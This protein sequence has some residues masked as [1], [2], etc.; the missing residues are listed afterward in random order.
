MYPV[1]KT[2]LRILLIV[3]GIVCFNA[4]ADLLIDISQGYDNPKKIAVVPFGGTEKLENFPQMAGII[5][6]D[7]ARSG[8]FTP[9][10]TE[11]ML[12]LPDRPSGVFFRDWRV[13]GVDFLLIG[14]VQKDYAGEISVSYHLYDVFNEREL[15]HDRLRGSAQ[16]GRDVAHR[17]SDKVYEKIT[18]IPGAFSTKIMYVLVQNLGSKAVLFELKLADSDGERARTLL[19]SREPILSDSW[20]PDGKSIT[21]VSFEGGKPSI[22]LQQIDSGQRTVLTHFNGLNSAPV[23]SPDGK[24]MAMVLSRDGNPE[25]YIM[26]LATRQLHRMT[27]NHSIDTEPSW[28]PDGKSIIFTSDRGGKPQVYALDLNSGLTERLT[29]VGDWNARARMLPDGKH[30]IYI[31]RENGVYHVALHDLV[32]DR[33]VALSTTDLDESPSIAP[34]GTMLIYATQERGRGILAVVS[35]DGQVRYRLPSSSGDVREPAWSPY[36]RTVLKNGEG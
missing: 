20:A 10:S 26:D 29:F 6:F 13:L 18:D 36:L 17:I 14:K 30:L 15:I 19:A 1:G 22:Y 5:S 25:I 16:Q 31:H 3:T 34:N 28:T 11:N 32:R 7:L 35:I 21:Y 23:F 12:S 27:R 9:L 24:R 2:G 4:H 8:Q 33:L